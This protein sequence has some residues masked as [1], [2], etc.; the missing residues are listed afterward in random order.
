MLSCNKSLSCFE[1]NEYSY[2]KSLTWLELEHSVFTKL[3]K[4]TTFRV[5]HSFQAD[6]EADSVVVKILERD[7]S[8]SSG[9]AQVGQVDVVFQRLEGRLD[10]GH[11]VGATDD[12]GIG[13]AH[14][15]AFQHRLH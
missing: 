8:A 1:S 13:S 11:L 10:S 6:L 4:G 5:H 15:D 12:I 9:L 2:L 14:S 3:A 7:V